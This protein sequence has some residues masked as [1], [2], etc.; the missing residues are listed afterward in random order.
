MRIHG[1]NRDSIRGNVHRESHGH[2]HSLRR[3]H[4]H[5]HVHI[6]RR[7][8]VTLG[9]NTLLQA[10]RYR[11]TL[12]CFDISSQH[13]CANVTCIHRVGRAML[14]LES[15][16][17]AKQIREFYRKKKGCSNLSTVFSGKDDNLACAQRGRALWSRKHVP[18]TTV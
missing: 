5:G 15:I 8:Q 2:V 16:K 10:S 6:L 3:K 9:C 1:N 4:S 11:T 13:D 14:V 12:E 18:T 17:I 7:K